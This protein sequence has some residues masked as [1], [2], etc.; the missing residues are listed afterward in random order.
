MATAKRKKKTT[1][2]PRPATS[3]LLEVRRAMSEGKDVVLVS[4]TLK[5][6]DVRIRHDGLN[7][8]YEIDRFGFLAYRPNAHS[9]RY[10]V[11]VDGEYAGVER[12]RLDAAMVEAV[13]QA[14]LSASNDSRAFLAD[15]ACR[16]LLVTNR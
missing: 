7:R 4:G 5:R 13:A 3:S 1:K 12:R 2:R 9:V 6:P 11:F 10:H 16:V 8:I 14:S 15:A